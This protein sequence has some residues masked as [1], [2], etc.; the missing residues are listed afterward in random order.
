[1]DGTGTTN[2]QIKNRYSIAE[3]AT[4]L[5]VSQEYLYECAADE[6]I[7]AY[8]YSRKGTWLRVEGKYIQ[9][10]LQKDNK[11]F[12]VYFREDK[13]INSE[14][15]CNACPHPPDD[16]SLGWVGHRRGFSF[17]E[18]CNA[19]IEGMLSAGCIAK[20]EKLVI[21][22][23]DLEFF[24]KKLPSALQ[25]TTDSNCGVANDSNG[26][27][28]ENQRFS[29]SPDYRSVTIYGKTQT[30]TPNQAQVIQILHCEGYENGSPDM[31]HDYILERIGTSSRI[32]QDIFRSNKDAYEALIRSDRKGTIRLNID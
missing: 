9:E 32:K 15:Q 24:R 8:L 26:S 19:H 6:E 31:S 18:K 14:E 28:N 12:E 10:A 7:P 13:A 29:H 17:N 22:K 16:P 21:Q 3:A 5:K 23:D 27:I 20:L 30:L 1:M 2:F 4:I 25:N 11:A